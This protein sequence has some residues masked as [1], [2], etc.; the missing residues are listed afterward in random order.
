MNNETTKQELSRNGQMAFLIDPLCTDNDEMTGENAAVRR[1]V[2]AANLEILID[3]SD[4]PEAL[5][6]CRVIPGKI[7]MEGRNYG[8]TEDISDFDLGGAEY[9][10]RK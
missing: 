4:H 2:D 9:R 1:L 5:G 3:T 8:Y 6:Q 10:Q 7:E